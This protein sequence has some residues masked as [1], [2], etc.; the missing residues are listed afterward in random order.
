MSGLYNDG[1]SAVVGT[2]LVMAAAAP[3]V[4]VVTVMAKMKLHDGKLKP[5][6]FFLILPYTALHCL[7]V[8]LARI[9][10]LADAMIDS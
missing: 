10:L 4:E 2:S 3:A 9:T 5:Y 6:A 7:T 1:R 8:L